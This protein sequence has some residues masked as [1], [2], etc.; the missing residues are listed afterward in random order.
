MQ[1][2]NTKKPFLKNQKSLNILA[3]LVALISI[4]I[5]LISCVL[6]LYATSITPTNTPTA[7]HTAT[8][9]RT[10]RPPTPTLTPTITP[11]PSITET[12]EFIQPTL[13]ETPVF[14]LLIPNI[15]IQ[16]LE[17][18]GFTCSTTSQTVA[19]LIVWSCVNETDAI[20]EEIQF[21]GRTSTTID[22]LN[23]HIQQ[24]LNPTDE[25]ASNFFG[26]LAELAYSG[27]SP[28]LPT[29]RTPIPLTQTPT[30]ESTL[31]PSPV[32]SGF[33]AIRE[34]IVVTLPKMTSPAFVEV[35]V[36]DTIPYRLKGNLSDSTLEIGV[37]LFE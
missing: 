16:N 5:F 7:T 32:V 9:T 24:K 3:I 2:G 29:E 4:I 11:T 26:M 21:G 23:G 8:I 14:P 22:F 1:S 12:I 36:F 10:P 6:D 17:V 37:F 15:I 13:G 28:T 33:E 19:N 30:S 18:N 34:W 27:L 25:I 35:N 31:T 20:S